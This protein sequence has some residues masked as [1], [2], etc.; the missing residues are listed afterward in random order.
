MKQQRRKS[1]MRSENIADCHN[2]FKN[3]QRHHKLRSVVYNFEWSFNDLNRYSS[4]KRA[5]TH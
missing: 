4:Y 1:N 5:V 3:K 2:T